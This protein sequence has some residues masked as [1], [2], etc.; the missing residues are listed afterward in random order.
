GQAAATIR[1]DNELWL[2]LAL[3]SGELDSLEPQHLAAALCALIT[4]TPRSDSWCEYPPPEEVLEALGI[5]KRKSE[6]GMQ[7]SVLREIRPHLFQTQHRYGLSMPIWREY[8][9]V[10]LSEQWALGVEWNELCQNTNLDEGDLVR[11]L[12][13]TIDVLWQIPQIPNISMVLE[14]NA[15]SAIAAMKRFPI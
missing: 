6:K 2:A 4:E 3:M 9:L 13:R 11:M 1:S 15:R 8:E 12:R 7:T 5:K 10:G 14:R